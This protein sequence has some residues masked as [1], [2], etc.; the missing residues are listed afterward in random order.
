MN[1]SYRQ[2]IIK[3]VVELNS[4][5]NKLGLIEI[6]RILHSTIIIKSHFSQVHMEDL[7]RFTTFWAIK[8]T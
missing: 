6:R 5:I 1:R 4:P 8:L 3:N 2:L 7:P